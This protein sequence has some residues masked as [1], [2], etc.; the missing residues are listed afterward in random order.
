MGNL[1]L[2]RYRGYLTLGKVPKVPE[3]KRAEVGARTAPSRHTLRCEMHQ[4][5]PPSP[6]LEGSGSNADDLYSP[7]TLHCTSTP[8]Q[9]VWECECECDRAK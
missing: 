4:S 6:P 9:K 1:P 5:T 7:C 2:L 3:V 8:A